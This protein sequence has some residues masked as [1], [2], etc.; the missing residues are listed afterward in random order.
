MR[1]SL[2]TKWSF[3][4]VTKTNRISQ[5]VRRRLIVQGA[6]AFR[7]A[8][9]FFVKLKRQCL[10]D[11]ASGRIVDLTSRI[12]ETKPASV[13]FEAVQ[14]Q[15]AFARNIFLGLMSVCAEK[16]GLAAESLVRTLFEVATNTIIL[17]KDPDKLSHFVRHGRL[18]ELRMI[19][20]IE[21]PELKERLADLIKETDE[22]FQ[23]LW[24]EFDERPWHNL[25]T[26]EALAEAEFEG[27]YVRSVFPPRFCNRTRPAV[28]NRATRKGCSATYSLEQSEHGRGEPRKAAHGLFDTNREPRI[29]AEPEGR[30][31]N[32]GCRGTGAY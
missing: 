26:K 4:R 25:K 31:S 30:D 27:W 6:R 29:H 2:E 28:C 18:T 12:I 8:L 32:L 20:F 17:A 24:E 14:A 5:S 7:G 21:Q 22:E 13:H 23:K 1:F 16:N 10:V 19:R 3:R 15:L 11:T 9:G